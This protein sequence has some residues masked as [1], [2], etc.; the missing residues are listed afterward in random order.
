MVRLQ[1]PQEGLFVL[2]NL[3][4]IVWF[5]SSIDEDLFIYVRMCPINF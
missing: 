5:I 2:N 1:G 3:F 4:I